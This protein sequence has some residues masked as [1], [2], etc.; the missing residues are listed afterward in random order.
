MQQQLARSD[1]QLTVHEATI[2]ATLPLAA[3]GALLPLAAARLASAAYEGAGLVGLPKAHLIPEIAAAPVAAR[4]AIALEVTNLRGASLPPA[5]PRLPPRVPVVSYGGQRCLQLAQ[6][7]IARPLHRMHSHGT[8]QRHHTAH[9]E[10]GPCLVGGDGPEHLPLP[11]VRAQLHR[12][13]LNRGRC[14]QLRRRAP[15]PC[16]R[17]AAGRAPIL[18]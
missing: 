10:E 3:I 7:G 17:R 18:L 16:R 8:A 5:R 1:E 11:L 6:R 12:H 14:A 9:A 13:S 15:V 4:E 2:A